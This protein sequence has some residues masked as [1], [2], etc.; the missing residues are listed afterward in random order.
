MFKT[1]PVAEAAVQTS[2][3]ESLAPA[4]LIPLSVLQLDLDPGEPWAA[5]LGRRGIRFVSDHIGRDAI[6]AGDAQRLIAERREHELRKLAVLKAADAEAVEADRKFRAS[7]PKGVPW[8][9]LP[10]GV[11]FVEAAAAAEAAEHPRRTPTRGEWLFGETDTMVYHELP[12]DE[13]S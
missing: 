10:D 5:F 9:A 6:S 4:D 11:S 7:L 8:Y 3:K 2:E 13:A 12:Q 1:V